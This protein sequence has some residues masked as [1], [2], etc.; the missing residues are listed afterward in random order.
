MIFGDFPAAEAEGVR[1][2]HTLRLPNLLLKKGRVLSA[3]DVAALTAAGVE[4]VAGAR[5]DAGELDEDAAART[6]AGL[7]ANTGIVP[8]PPYTGRCNL[9]AQGAGVL[10]VDRERIDRLNRI[11]EAITLAT[12]PQHAC[13][14]RDQRVA[15]VK[16]IP[17]AVGPR[18]VDA[19]RELVGTRSPLHL[20]PLRT[21]RAALIMGVSPSTGER[22]LDMTVTATRGRLEALGSTLALTLRCAHDGPAVTQ[23]LQQALAA[24][25]DLVLVMGATVSKDRADVVPAAIVAAGGVIEHFGMPVEPGNMLLTARIGKVPVFNL[26]GCA[27]SRNHN[28]IDLLLQRLLA[29]LL[30]APYDIMRLGVGGLLHSRED[31][32]AI[33]DPGQES[34]PAAA[35]AEA[36]APEPPRVAALVLAAGRST[37][38]GERNKLLCAVDGVPLVLRAANAA[39]ASRA[40]QVMVVTGHEAERVEAALDGRPVSFTHNPDYAQGMAGSL[41]R[42]LRALRCDVDAVIVLLADMPGI[43]A[44]VV[45]RMIDAFDPAQPA[46]LVPEHAG[47]RGNP[48][49]WP[50]RFFAEMAALS[51]DT[52]ARGLLEQYAR[53]VRRVPFDS[54][55]IFAD[56]DT[57]EALRALERK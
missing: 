55:A 25:C 5:L 12:L 4:R 27:R 34:A 3:G 48:I 54:P 30:L 56:V 29:G 39:C 28:G 22:L 45:D 41:R 33:V 1:L 42:G 35:P 21:C 6:V 47:R 38:M 53:E 11:S 23:A 9:Y 51:G 13:V 40:C 52:G 36:P 32:E 19:W 37:R 46:I 20:A 50:R 44:A 10:V 43:D 8:R 14:G 2:A 24:G 26:P 17:F 18:C 7:L 16:I 15:T 49:L 57:P 31:D